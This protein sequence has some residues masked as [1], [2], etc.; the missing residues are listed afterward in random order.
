MFN[1]EMV[2]EATKA[3]GGSVI[4][5]LVASND[6]P[7]SKVNRLFFAGLS[8]APT[9]QETKM[10]SALIGSQ[11]NMAEGLRDLWWVIL[12]SNEFIFNH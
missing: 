12:N 10:A 3:R 9:S 7:R 2:N 8:R 6:S 1:G 4:E 5:Q 11:A